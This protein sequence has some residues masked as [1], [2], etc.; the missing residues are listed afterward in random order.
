M[1]LDDVKER[2][3]EL[4]L[5]KPGEVVPCTAEEVRELER[6]TGRA[7]P[8][9][10]KEF[11]LWMGHGAG[12]LWLGSHCFYRDLE[13]LGDWAAVML[14]R[15]DPAQKLPEDA[16]VFLMHQGYQFM[17][18]RTSEGD[19][20]PVYYYKDEPE[21]LSFSIREQHFSRFLLRAIESHA[22]FTD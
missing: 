12:E 22:E 8:Q 2:A 10:Y 15:S 5:F 7:L 4:D 3:R 21:Q 16:F 6:R 18:F 17:F 20:P 9:A 19:D 1:Y 14:K 11:L 13:P